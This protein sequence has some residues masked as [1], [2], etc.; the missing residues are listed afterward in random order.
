VRNSEVS[1]NTV[2][3]NGAS[4]SAQGGGIF[5]APIA[6]GPPGGPLKLLNSGVTGNA[7]NGSP[8]IALQGGG[9]YIEN[10]PLTLTN[11]FIANNSPD[12]CFGC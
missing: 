11:S 12:Q 6:D 5:D 3:A 8:G 2:G 1:G 7:L 10:K 4:G 9:L